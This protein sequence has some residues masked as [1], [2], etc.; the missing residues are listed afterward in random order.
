MVEEDLVELYK[1]NKKSKDPVGAVQDPDKI[2]KEKDRFQKF[3]L[4]EANKLESQTKR[5]LN[6]KKK[7]V[8]KPT[9]VVEITICKGLTKAGKNCTHKAINGTEFCGLHKK[10]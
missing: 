6:K 3:M 5:L 2:L 7:P 10:T 4:Y 1:P 9:V 8:T